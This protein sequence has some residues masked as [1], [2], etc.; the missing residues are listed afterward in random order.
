MDGRK[1]DSMSK[2]NSYESAREDAEV[3]AAISIIFVG[4]ILK[5]MFYA[6]LAGGSIMLLLGI[7]SSFG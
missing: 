2:M 7:I 4:D 5:Y 3:L 1:R 6:I